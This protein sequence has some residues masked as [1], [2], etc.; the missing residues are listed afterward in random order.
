MGRIPYHLIHIRQRKGKGSEIG[1]YTTIPTYILKYR[2]LLTTSIFQRS[3]AYGPLP[4]VLVQP[5]HHCKKL[6]IP[7]ECRRKSATRPSLDKFRHLLA[8]DFEAL[9]W[10]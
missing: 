2:G 8:A 4:A 6:W 7:F 9:T 10:M 1:I 3:E 5:P